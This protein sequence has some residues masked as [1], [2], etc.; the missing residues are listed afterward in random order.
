QRSSRVQPFARSMATGIYSTLVFLN[1]L[2]ISKAC[3]I[4]GSLYMQPNWKNIDVKLI[5]WR[6]LWEKLLQIYQ[7]HWMVLSLG[8]TTTLSGSMNGCSAARPIADSQ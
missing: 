7:C 8:R 5:T 2:T 4:T 1:L 3:K 6:L